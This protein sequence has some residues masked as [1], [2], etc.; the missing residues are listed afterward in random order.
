MKKNISDNNTENTGHFNKMNPENNSRQQIS[1][2]IVA[3]AQKLS[4]C[5][6]SFL[7]MLKDEGICILSASSIQTSNNIPKNDPFFN[8]LVTFKEF[9]IIKE[10]QAEK[11]L[12]KSE[13]L[14][15]IGKINYMAIQPIVNKEN[16]TL[17]Y[18]VVLNEEIP[19]ANLNIAE[20]LDLLYPQTKEVLIAQSSE[21]EDQILSKAMVLS[22]DLITILGADGKLIKVNKAFKTLLGYDEKEISDKPV[23]DY[24]HPDDVKSTMKQ[25]QSLITGEEQTTIF[26]HRLKCQNGEYK[27]FAWR[28]TG[29]LEN[30]LVFAIGRDISEETKNKE[31]LLA[32]EEKFR[33]FFENSQGLMLTHD[34]EGNFLSFNSYGARLLGYTVEEMLT[35]KLWDIIPSKFKFEVDDYIKEIKDNGE[36]QGLMTTFQANGQLKVWLY[37]NKLEK[38]HFGNQ[39]VIGNSID[40][41]ERLRLEKR[42]QNA[43]EFLNQTHA[44]AKI[45]GWKYD[46]EKQSINWTDITKSIFMVSDEYIPD[47][48][49]G[50]DFYKE[51]ES[52][53]KIKEVI[54]L[55]INYGKPWD[56]RLKIINNQGKEIW[57]RTLGEAHI[58][59]GKCLYLSGTIQDIDE[60]V[61]KENQ[62]IQKEQMLGAISK[63]TDELLSNNK[64]YDAIPNS[65]EI[66]GK[67]VGVDRIYYF[68]NSMG[69]KGEK[70]TSQRFEWSNDSVEAQ[71]NNPD[72][73]NIPL[74]AFGDFVFPMENNEVFM[75][76]ISNL[77]DE[78]ETKQFLD[79]QNIKSILTIPIFTENG[80]WGFIGYDDCTN[81]REWS[82]A[83]LSLLR[84]FANSISNAIDRNILEKNLIESKEIAEKASLA[85]S[86]FLANM[87]HEIRTP[88][89]GIIGFTDLLVKTELDETQSQYINIVNQSAVS[90]LNIIND[91]LD[92]SKIEAGKLE[93]EIIKSD[94]F[95]LSGQATD[96]VSYQAQKK[97]VEM[98]LN[99]EKSLP[100]FIKVDDIRLK[101]I[102]IN[103][104][105]NAVKFTDKGEIELKIHTLNKIDEN[106]RIIR[107][108][109]RDTGI[110]IS[111]EYQKRIFDAFMQE[112]GSTTKKYGGT[113]LG[114]TISNKLLSMMGSELQ[115]KSKLNA[116]STFYFDLELNTEEGELEQLADYPLNNVLVVDDNSNNRYILK[117]IFSL[118]DIKVDEAENGFEAL[119]QI[120]NNDYDVVLM[121]LNMP[122][123]DGIETT[124]KIRENFTNKKS[125]VPILL[126]HSSA[127]D[128]YILKQCKELSINRRI[129]KPIKNK[130]LFE[131]LSKLQP[132]KQSAPKEIKEQADTQKKETVGARV[133][134]AEDNSINMFLAK[135]IVLKVSPK[136]E[137][138]EATN[139]LDAYEMATEYQP[140]IILMD[141]QMPVMSGHEATKK[142]KANPK[143]KDIPIIAI[144]AG[145]IKGEKEKCMDSGMS[146]F[147]PKPIVEKNI[148][149]IFDRWLKTKDAATTSGVEEENEKP[150]EKNGS[151][152]EQKDH[153]DV[154]K[155]K[156][157]LGDEPEIIK[158]VLKLTIHELGQS[159][160][161][162]ADHYNNKDLG[163]L[164][165]EGHKLKGS[166]LTA[167]LGEVFKTA[168]ALEEMN[169]LDLALA[170]KLIDSYD[171]EYELV[172][173]LINDYIANGN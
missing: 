86:E 89:N 20:N 163:G 118:N 85:K 167:G 120:E 161:V 150:S 165:S 19:P 50:I 107:F 57:V 56:E 21:L 95:E 145:N 74:E 16:S 137:I 153:F 38:D 32:S 33:S 135:T 142:L 9:T 52:R 151:I 112:D 105:G 6:H 65:L 168:L 73:Q 132:P 13:Y 55:A 24:I 147:V 131:A 8:F 155:V 164:S 82:K 14:N 158:E 41:T 90:L 79:N 98:L 64:L 67:S 2:K 47:L 110:G 88:L 12:A 114:L 113:G 129:S 42:I 1:S 51:G 92:F 5:N 130:E 121:D 60:E 100:R 36:A 117:E 39:Y 80:F 116:G 30:N 152:N 94:I 159:K 103:L 124:K 81:E 157:F 119:Q 171:L 127:E 17:G 128:D 97:G 25:I 170:K 133:L 93:L 44:M 35:K 108:E 75:A 143:T 34:M 69:E 29:D 26:Y 40:I 84:S 18:V 169:T 48:E 28:A 149:Y 154:D 68:E 148:I 77:P 62:L 61:K 139:G 156:E 58:E 72:L 43:K 10:I 125:Q 106:K 59:D 166:A 162:L 7:G 146:D 101:Q 11:E 3:L 104:L 70:Y 96:V 87:S 138:F 141:I 123:M 66:I 76:I 126:L 53:D 63:A 144:T 49:T 27:T 140:D 134:I 4:A 136:V 71:I 99:I 115:L 109:V 54:D 15:E 160:T 111:E 91:I 122:Y 173:G 31:R 46:I 45:G 102:L 23:L 22:Q 83:E 172:V 78:S 37:S